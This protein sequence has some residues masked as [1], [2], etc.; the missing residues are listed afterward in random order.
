MK[1]APPLTL[2]ILFSLSALFHF[3][4]RVVSRHELCFRVGKKNSSHAISSLFSSAR[5]SIFLSTFFLSFVFPFSSW[6]GTPVLSPI[7]IS[8]VSFIAFAR[9][10]SKGKT[11]RKRPSGQRSAVASSDRS[12]TTLFQ[13]DHRA[14]DSYTKTRFPLRRYCFLFY[15]FWGANPAFTY[16][17][18]LLRGTY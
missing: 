11:L 6:R 12:T 3:F 8:N 9:A 4:S 15:S 18:Y 16:C 5:R 14:C 13:M 10:P 2:A 7:S 1:R 17:I